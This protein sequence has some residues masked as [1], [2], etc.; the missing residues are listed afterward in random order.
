MKSRMAE[1]L[2]L[3]REPV[4]ICWSDEKPPL[5]KEFKKGK[6]GCVMWLFAAAAQ[7]KSA[8]VSADTYGCWGGGVGLGF[9]NQYL[10]FPAGMEGFCRFLATGN[11]GWDKGIETARQMEPYVSKE[12]LE[13]YLRGEGYIKT[14]A[15]VEDFVK[16]LPMTQVPSRHVLLKPLSDITY[17]GELPRVVVFLANPDQ[18]SALVILANY[19]RSGNENVIIPY[20]A[21]CQTI[22]IYPY[23]EAESSSPRAVVGLTDISA[24][25]N[26]KKQLGGE[27]LSFS[28]PWR[29]FLEMEQDVEGSF[30]TR[31]TWRSLRGGE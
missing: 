20:A 13:D 8:V 11:A 4:A 12:F 30:L 25:L 3:K 21:G 5:A 27:F 19:G 15:L 22:G 28:M 31:R 2:G 10:K 17:E 24:R 6:W 26:L 16:N 1:A 7:G 9:G 14:P 29:M 23:R 18:I